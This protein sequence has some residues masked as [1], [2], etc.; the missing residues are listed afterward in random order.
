MSKQPRVVRG[1]V[2]SLGQACIWQT[3]VFNCIVTRLPYFPLLHAS[4]MDTLCN[5]VLFYVFFQY[6]NPTKNFSLHLEN[7]IFSLHLEKHFRPHHTCSCNLKQL[8]LVVRLSFHCSLS[9]KV[10]NLISKHNPTGANTV[11]FE[12]Y[13][14]VSGLSSK[15]RKH[16][17]IN[18]PPAYH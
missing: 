16:C 11:V 4:R 3:T 5:W 9:K 7:P 15:R 14:P 2:C 6:P 18:C 8:G 12:N 1:I 13:G 17:N 10:A